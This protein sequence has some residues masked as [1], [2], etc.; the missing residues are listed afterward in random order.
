MTA[1]E[2]LMGSISHNVEFPEPP[3]GGVT[4]TSS[5]PV[6]VRGTVTVGFGGVQVASGVEME[7]ALDGVERVAP[8]GTP[9][10]GTVTLGR[11]R[12]R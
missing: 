11:R 6:R 7:M 5:A 2:A 10:S 4:M 1:R 8:R 3:L 12:S 9:M